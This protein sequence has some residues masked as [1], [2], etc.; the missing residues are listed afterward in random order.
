M[1][2]CTLC[3]NHVSFKIPPDDNRARFVCHSCGEIHYQNP[4]NVVGTIPLWEEK[5]LLCRR[6]IEPRRGLWTLPAGFLELQETTAQGAQRETLE[7]A[8]AQIE[9]GPLFSILNVAHIGQVHWFY[10]AQ[11]KSANFSTSTSESLEVALFE[12]KEIPWDDIAFLTVKTTLEHFFADRKSGT[13][14]F[15]EARPTHQID[16]KPV[17]RND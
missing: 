9:I 12:E 1:K 15:T 6:A 2:Y 10:L 17:I 11:M 14:S 16:L 4:K 13:I 8:G 5:I 7:E 3:G